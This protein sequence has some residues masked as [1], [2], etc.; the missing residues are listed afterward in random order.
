M[1]GNSLPSVTTA[2]LDA[3]TIAY[4]LARNEV[5]ER[6]PIRD[7]LTANNIDLASPGL[8]TLLSSDGFKNRYA[9]FVRELKES[10]ES[11]KLKARVQAEELLATQWKIIHDPDAPHSVRME[12]IKNV[13]EWADLKP[14]KAASE[15]GNQTPSISIHIDLG[16]ARPEVIDITPPIQ[17]DA[18]AAPQ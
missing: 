2:S 14:K 1:A 10:G 4:A 6:L 7:V 13:V 12:G 15:G 9:S 17:A 5:G 16:A 8:K 3:N 11:F 18:I